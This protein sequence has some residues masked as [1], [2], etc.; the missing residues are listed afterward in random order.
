MYILVSKACNLEYKRANSRNTLKCIKLILLKS[1]IH[2][3][4]VA[5]H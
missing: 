5:A 4:Y 2:E 1:R 3:Q